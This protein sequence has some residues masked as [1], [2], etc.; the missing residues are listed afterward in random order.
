[1]RQVITFLSVVYLWGTGLCAEELPENLENPNN[2]IADVLAHHPV[3][4]PPFVF[5]EAENPRNALMAVVPEPERVPRQNPRDLRRAR[6]Q[7]AVF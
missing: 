2:M 6:R 5:L 1:M 3:N 7:N 4:P